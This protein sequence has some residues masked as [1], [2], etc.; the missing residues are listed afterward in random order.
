MLA[1]A[2]GAA[3]CLLAVILGFV[4]LAGIV[5]V[6]D[7]AEALELLAQPLLLLGAQGL[8]GGAGAVVATP[9]LLLLHEQRELRLQRRE[10]LRVRGADVGELVRILLEVE[11]H[12]AA[13]R[14]LDQLPAAGRERA[15]AEEG[16]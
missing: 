4:A 3:D 14:A 7:V 8:D 13:L 15:L 11:E 6:A 12:V 1:E 16:R 5:V 9:L 2:A 10:H